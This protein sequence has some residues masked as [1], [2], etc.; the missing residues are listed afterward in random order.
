MSRALDRA[1]RAPGDAA[2]QLAK[3]EALLAL[4]RRQAAEVAALELAVQIAE[5]A[6]RL[7]IG[8][9][10]GATGDGGAREGATGD[11]AQPDVTI[12]RQLAAALRLWTTAR[13]RQAQPLDDPRIAAHLERLRGEPA[14]AALRSWSESLA[15]RAPYRIA[16]GSLAATLE[17]KRSSVWSRFRS[18][19]LEGL[20]ATVGDVTLDRVFVDT[21]AQHTLLSPDA[22]R[23]AGVTSGGRASEMVGFATF[24]A[25]PGLIRELR[26]GDLVVRDV[27]VFVGDSPA[28]ARAKGQMLIGTDLLCHLRF[29]LDLAADRAVI[30][31]AAT[32]APLG[33]HAPPG[34]WQVRL[35]PL[36]QT[37]LAEARLDGGAYA[38]VLIDT[39]NW[40]GT[41]VSARWA[42]RH[43]ISLDAQRYL[44]WMPLEPASGPS[45]GLEFDGR[46]LGDH[47]VHGRL[48]GRAGPVGPG[49]RHCRPRSARSAARDDRS[50]SARIALRKERA[51][52]RRWIVLATAV[53]CG[54][55]GLKMCVPDPP[56]AAADP[57]KSTAEFTKARE[58]MVEKEIVAAGVKNR[59]VIAAMRDTPRHEFMPISERPNAYLDMALPIGESQTISPPFV[60]AYMTE[61][62]DPQPTDKVL[63]IGTGSGYQAAVLSPLVKEVYTI[64]IVKA[65][66]DRA[67]RT[68]KRLDYKNVSARVGDGYQGW[69]E[70]APFDKIIVTCSPEKVPEALVEQLKEGGRMIVPVG[71]RYQQT[72]YLFEKNK[73]QL[74]SVALLP[75]LFVPMTGQA[76]D[77][78][79]VQ[80]DPTNPQVNNGSFERD[81][82]GVV[83]GWHYQRQIEWI[84]DKKAPASK[85]YIA[86]HNEDPGRGA[87]LAGD[88]RRRPQSARAGALGL[89]QRQER[90]SRPAG[91]GAGNRLHPVLRRAPG[92]AVAQFFGALARNVRLAARHGKSRRAQP[93]PRGDSEYRLARGHGRADARR[94]AGQRRQEEVSPAPQQGRLAAR[95]VSFRRGAGYHQGRLPPPTTLPP[96]GA[97]AMH[98]TWKL[99]SPVVGIVAVICTLGLAASV[100]RAADPIE[101]FNGKDLTGWKAKHADNTHWAAGTAALN[102]QNPGE[103]KLAAGSGEL[104]NTKGGGSDL[105][106]EQKFGDGRYEVEVMVPKGS[107]SGIYLMGEYEIQVFDSFGKKDIGM[108]DMGAI[109]TRCGAEAQCLEGAGR[110]AEVRDRF[111]R[112]QVRR[113]RQED[114]QRQGRQSHA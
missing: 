38:R 109:Y 56:P 92:A 28:L 73:G 55:A 75:T 82:N 7:A 43:D 86:F 18:R 32:A 98:A 22:A 10:E 97:P 59:R 19:Q 74:K 112:A 83:E 114:G 30:E 96:P 63:E 105:Y 60:V 113:R 41:Y 94:R 4:G 14:L 27:P 1:D 99:R 88:G 25:V 61:Q 8:A 95:Q 71:E 64:E 66:G 44:R 20:E 107:N 89:G 87:G 21:G 47:P 16:S 67:K 70:A 111:S 68:L 103:L 34:G 23:A 85:H 72:L 84:E 51:M 62:I 9:R 90:A 79:D 80:P 104:V 93:G 39:A 78:R 58:L 102:P 3:I 12:G 29:T 65:L 53:L 52:K 6:D 54:I 5:L 46:S 45:I 35:W 17:L 40:E 81:A 77:Q 15:G 100:S 69:P 50:E 57:P 48:A 33:P 11:I 24:E 13:L 26:L 37:C 108:G 31:P 110:M 106:T 2:A 36:V 42:R 91:G 101:P 76:E 49:G